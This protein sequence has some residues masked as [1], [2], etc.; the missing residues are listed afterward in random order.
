MRCLAFCLAV[1]LGTASITTAMLREPSGKDLSNKKEI[2]DET[3][4]PFIVNVKLGTHAHVQANAKV[5]HANGGR[6]SLRATSTPP[7]FKTKH[8]METDREGLNKVLITG[9]TRD[10]ILNLEG[11]LSVSLDR[12]NTYQNVPWGQDR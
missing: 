6:K 3:Y 5:V 4:G 10:E 9:L 7:D 11:V 8:L 1:L 2:A 12:L